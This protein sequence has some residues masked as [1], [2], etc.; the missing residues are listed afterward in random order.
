MTIKYALTKLEI[1]RSFFRS[2]GG[3]PRLL[4]IV[5]IYS[6]GLGLYSLLMRGAFTRSF[7]ADDA[8]FAVAST[9][10]AF[11]FIPFWVFIRGKTAERTLTVSEKGISTEIGSAKG[12]IP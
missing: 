6:V 7:R 11:L 9:V 3:S 1:A 5:S 8:L 12:E 2:L 10:G 4:T